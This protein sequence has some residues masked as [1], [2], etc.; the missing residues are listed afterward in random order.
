MSSV[1]RHARLLAATTLLA[2]M[3][4][5]SAWA[6]TVDAALERL[7]VLV[8]EQGAT[9]EWASAD[10][11][12]AD[13]VL[14]DVRV[15]AGDDLIPIGN[16]TLAG[17]SP[18]DE[19][20]LVDSISMDRYFMDDGSGSSVTVEEV[21]MTGVII[22]A[23][24]QE[25]QFGGSLFYETADVGSVVV[26]A[27]G[28]EVF[29]LSDFHVEMT[30]P[31]NGN[32][33]DFSGA[34]EGFTIDLSGIEDQQQKQI[35]QALGYEKLQG[36]M[37]IAGSWQPTDGRMTLSQYD[38]AIVDA[39]T[40]GMTVDIGGYTTDFIASLREIQK[41]MADNPE[42]DNSA[43]G[44]A[45]MGLM[46]QL[47]FHGANITFS[48][49]SLTAKV[50]EFVAQ[51]QGMKP[52]DIANQAKAVLPFALAQLNNSE[53]TTQATQAVSAFLDNPKSL[54]IAAEPAQPVPFALIMAGAMSNPTDLT[55]TLAVGVYANE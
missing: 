18:V 7:K 35:L 40:L 16:V 51:S 20:Y 5:G 48:D 8:E 15:G 49:D 31:E 22:P 30:R 6:Q 1:L 52:A 23:E 29:T 11:S 43:Q 17:I 37:E 32:P 46:Q 10:I 12:G 33:M 21:G 53:L 36:Y 41:Q 4:L 14:V 50:L 13:A 44:L 34:A 3:P 24:G 45:I 25:D 39:G 55:K 9:M 28:T 47:T 42:G 27:T 54:R 2:A 19:G 26:N 38:L